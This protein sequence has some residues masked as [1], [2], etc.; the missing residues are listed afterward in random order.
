MAHHE[1]MWL[2]AEE[3]G[4]VAVALAALLGVAIRWLVKVGT[5]R[6]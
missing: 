3:L 5:S 6:S 2:H 4:L 1:C